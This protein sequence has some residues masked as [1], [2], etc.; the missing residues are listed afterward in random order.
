M[1]SLGAPARMLQNWEPGMTQQQEVPPGMTQGQLVMIQVASLAIGILVP[2]IVWIIVAFMY[3][4]QV[5]DKRGKFP[6]PVP[7]QF[8]LNGK[9]FKYPTFRFFDDMQYCLHGWC[10]ADVR[11]ADTYAMTEIVPFWTMC[12]LYLAMWTVY[13]LLA[14]GFQMLFLRVLRVNS[15]ANNASNLAY[16]IANGALAAY[17]ATQRKKLREKLG[18]TDPGSKFGGDCVCYWLCGCCTFIQDARQVDEAS[19][20][21]VECCCELIRVSHPWA[22]NAAVVVG[23][24]VVVVGAVVAK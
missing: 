4:T 10:C 5:T 21:K 11:A 6:D 19:G 23:A 8:N 2:I 9:D 18:D 12:L 24:P 17:L 15:Q 16:F 14:F 7:P 3:K 1:G 13:Q 20:T 22:P